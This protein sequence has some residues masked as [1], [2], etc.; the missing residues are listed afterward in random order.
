LDEQRTTCTLQGNSDQE[1]FTQGRS[2]IRSSSGT[3]ILIIPASMT[4]G[5][6]R[7]RKSEKFIKSCSVATKEGA[8]EQQLCVPPVPRFS[9]FFAL[10]ASRCERFAWAAANASTIRMFR[11]SSRDKT[12]IARSSLRLSWRFKP[13]TSKGSYKRSL[14]KKVGIWI[15]LQGSPGWQPTVRGCR[16]C[17]LRIPDSQSADRCVARLFSDVSCHQDLGT[18]KCT[19][20]VAHNTV[21]GSKKKDLGV[22]A[23]PNKN[24]TVLKLLSSPNLGA[25]PRQ[26]AQF[27]VVFKPPATSEP[28]ERLFLEFLLGFCR[29]RLPERRQ[30]HRTRTSAESATARGHPPR[31]DC[32][33][34]AT[35]ESYSPQVVSAI[36][37]GFE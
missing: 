30:S 10:S 31:P 1:G 5:V 13:F 20:G 35:H 2:L 26:S 21:S 32:T 27:D 34:S 24:A 36:V 6:N 17:K 15:E 7:F 19:A 14:A 9:S 33:V 16:W 37:V 28:P 11:S 3:V 12:D 18:P 22:K 4:A 8:S 23:T 29:R 25:L